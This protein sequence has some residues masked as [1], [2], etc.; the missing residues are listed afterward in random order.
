VDS[1]PTIVI[2][3][4]MGS[5][6]TAV[7]QALAALLNLPM[8]DLDEFITDA[9]G[10]TSAQIIGDDG[11][12]A[13]RKIET[14]AL[15]SLLR[16]PRGVIALGGGA[17]IEG[18]NRTLIDE[19]NCLTIWL[20]TSFAECWKRIQSSEEERPL[21]KTEQQAKDLFERRRPV[22]EL[23]TLHLR[24]LDNETADELAARLK[25]HVANSLNT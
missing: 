22:Y 17:W 23:A 19:H 16:A 6:K 14:D 5:G 15:R 2:T 18:T 12:R 21:G 13:F 25:A 11:E 7:A 8:I 24:V 20:D 10:R 3:G 1:V 9:V 4:F